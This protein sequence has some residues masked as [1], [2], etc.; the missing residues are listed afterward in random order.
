MKNRL[1]KI[2]LC[3]VLICCLL[4]SPLRAFKANSASLTF[5][6]EKGNLIID[7]DRETVTVEGE[8]IFDT[9]VTNLVNY[10]GKYRPMMP[11]LKYWIIEEGIT[12]I[13]NS[14]FSNGF[15]Y[16]ESIQLPK[17]LQIIGEEAFSNAKRLKSIVIPEGVKSIDEKAFYG[18][19]RLKTITNL[20]DQTVYLP[21][22][23]SLSET[24]RSLY[25]YYIDGKAVVSVPPGKTA[26]GSARKFLVK[27]VPDGGKLK[28][29]TSRDIYFQPGKPLKLPKA[30]KKG[31]IF[32]GWTARLNSNIAWFTI[33][34]KD[35][36]ESYGSTFFWGGYEKPICV[37]AQYANI[38]SKKLGKRKLNLKLSELR[39]TYQ[40]KIQY[41]TNKKFKKAKSIT[42]KNNL[43]I[44]KKKINK[45]Q[46]YLLK[47]SRKKKT[48]SVT[49]SKLKAGKKYYFRFQY[50]GYFPSATEELD[51][52]R[53]GD[54][55]KKTVKM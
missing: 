29:N 7:D 24:R 5:R 8:G 25:D 38:K 23:P 31:Y 21:E 13:K 52:I 16:M 27:L 47:F 15:G 55:F 37:Y 9:S 41:S 11:K 53:F 22:H 48:L 50:Q 26:V 30:K 12:K 35:T 32:C 28:G 44:L 43:Q 49:L 19:V 3:A 17:S 18:C 6:N 36:D 51:V 42:V 14:S 40:L 10:D 39:K 54:W 2:N 46:H 20:S 1:F 33:T 34:G 45:K 4:I